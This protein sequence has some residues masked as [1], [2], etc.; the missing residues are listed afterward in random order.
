MRVK[1]SQASATAR[2]RAVS[3]AGAFKSLESL[4]LIASD[5]PSE[6]QVGGGTAGRAAPRRC[7]AVC[8]QDAATRCACALGRM[9]G[10]RVRDE[11]ESPSLD[12]APAAGAAALKERDAASQPDNT[13]AAV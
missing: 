3:P 10:K 12:N 11:L 8:S 2:A 5:A 13:D 4:L 1:P 7:L 9:S 6:S